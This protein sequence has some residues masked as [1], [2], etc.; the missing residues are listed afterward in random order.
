MEDERRE[1]DGTYELDARPT[2]EINSLYIK[3]LTKASDVMDFQQTVCG[4]LGIESPKNSMFN[5]TEY[6]KF[7]IQLMRYFAS[8]QFPEHEIIV[9]PGDSVRIRFD[10]NRALHYER[11]IPSPPLIPDPA[12]G[13]RKNRFS[14]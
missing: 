12:A 3:Y 5:S 7:R 13:K 4:L 8:N 1:N 11:I 6:M 10:V 14:A 9:Y 2:V